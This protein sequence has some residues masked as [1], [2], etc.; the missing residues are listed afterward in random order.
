MAAD[1]LTHSASARPLGG[2]L[3]TDQN[4]EQPDHSAPGAQSHP[5]PQASEQQGYPPPQQGYEQQGYPPPPQGQPGQ[6]YPG[7]QGHP[8]QQGYPGQPAYAGQHY[9]QMQPYQYGPPGKI[10][11]T[12][13][14]MLLYF[15]TLGIYGWVYYYQT[16]EEMKKHAGEGL[17]GPL[18]LVLAIFVGIV[19]PY[20]M[21]S[22]VGNLY[23]RQGREKPVT[24]LTGLWVF[25]G[26]FILVGPFIWF[27]KTNHA[28]N[29]YWESMGARP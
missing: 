2:V 29:E 15:V 28:L 27:V 3:V 4:S 13:L 20:I 11:P 8:G 17:G 25:P 22:E 12:G 6:G 14:S 7:P 18:A 19:M 24:A 10:R 16:H 21:S 5:P 23:E 1:L 9:G 26:I